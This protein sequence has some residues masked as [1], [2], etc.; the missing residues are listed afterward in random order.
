MRKWLVV[1]AILH[2]VLFLFIWLGFPRLP[3][4]LPDV[5]KIIPVDIA[6]I[7]EITAAKEPPPPTPAPKPKVEPPK[8]PEPPKPTPPPPT[9]TPTPP[10]PAS[11][12]K[13]PEPKPPVKEEKAEPVPAPKPKPPKPEP[14]KPQQDN[15]SSILKN[16]AKLKPQEKQEE[17][18][19][20]PP[21]KE[22]TPA[23]AAPQVP[24]TAERL[25]A[26]EE[27]ALRRQLAQCWNVPIGARDVDRMSVDIYIAVNQDRT[28]REAVVVDQARMASDPFFRTLAESALRALYN[29]RCSPLALPPEKYQEW[30][31]TLIT[32]NP[33]DMF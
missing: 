10:A 11:T 2:F 22:P 15:L 19:P 20:A 29:P 16:V 13:P 24:A 1:S 23:P 28:V 17:T 27:D 14:P 18:K 32:F 25:T 5:Q 30:H 9:P 12:P 26:S 7:S 6:D 4:D 8:P 3:R 21:Q 31:D 33:K